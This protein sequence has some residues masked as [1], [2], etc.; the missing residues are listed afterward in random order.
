MLV[1]NVNTSSTPNTLTVQRGVN[2]T[3][4][5]SH[6]AGAGVY[7]AIDQRGNARA[8]PPD[9]GAFQLTAGA[10]RTSL[11]LSS[12]NAGQSATATL[13][14]L[15]SSSN[16]PSGMVYFLD[17]TTNTIVGHAALAPSSG[18]YVASVSVTSLTPGMHVI[19]ALYE[20]DSNFQGSSNGISM[21]VAAAPAPAVVVSKSS[22]DLGT[23]TAGVA[24]TL[25]SYTV[26]GSNLTASVV[27]TAP[28]GVELS[29]DG[30]TWQT[31]ETLNG[32]SGT[33]LSTT[34]DARISASALSGSISGNISNTSTGATEQD[35][36]VSGT[37]NSG[38]PGGS[39]VGNRIDDGTVQRSMV[40]SITLTFQSA[41][42]SANLKVVLA[43]L[44]L[45]RV[46]DGL[47]VGLSGTLDGTGKVLTLTFTGSSIIGG[48][49]PDGRY[50]L[51]YGGSTV[52]SSTNLWRLFGDLSGTA[53]VTAADEK[54]FLTAL[55]SRKGMSNYSVYFDYNEDGVIV[56]TDQTAFMQR[57]GTSI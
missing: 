2:G 31:S 25:Q 44:S 4:A 19:Q 33:L 22:L 13:T 1:T 23:T 17:A 48:S 28:T 27:V 45:K 29:L 39:V 24:G 18:D 42:S 11:S 10:A 12:T 15:D 54:A 49:L 40:R 47:S 26:S 16:T 56:S 32:T 41:I 20:G 43:S 3:T 50:N 46:S 7:L 14:F 6:A 36:A 9:I 30:S 38:L 51:T 35:V 34:I 55:N 5:A 52:I 37:V 8:T 53:S 21:L 57:Y